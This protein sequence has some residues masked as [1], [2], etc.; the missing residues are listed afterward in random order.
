MILAIDVGNS[1]IVV[2]C[3]EENIRFI[4]RMSTDRKKTELEYAVSIKNI[5]EIYHIQEGDL[6]GGIISSVVPQVTEVLKRAV[7]KLIKAPVKIV[8]PGLKTG[9]N[10]LIDNPA[11]L[12]GDLL[13]DSVAA[14]AEHEAPLIVI[15]MGT[16]TTVCVINEKKQY[17]GGM[18]LP[19]V[20]TSLDSLVSNTSLL[21]QI[22]L[23]PP[24]KVIGSN[25]IEGMKSGILYGNA[26]AMDGL[27]ERI[28]E[29]LGKTCTIVATGG[30]AKFVI[31]FCKREIVIDDDLLLKGLKI[32]Y[33]KNR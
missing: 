28:E 17:L 9:L 12:G 20:R 24:S 8:G 32:I 31:P 18:I 15:D 1:N 27:I 4:E 30:L 23:E 26:A 2:G 16:A 7:E 6:E 14:M 10:I 22:G 21:Q 3:I 19:G 29:E 11:Q 13:V 25:T 33:D 5:M